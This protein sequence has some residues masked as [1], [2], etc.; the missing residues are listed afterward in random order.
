MRIL[1]VTAAGMSSR[2]A[3]SLG[4]E[5]LKCIYYKNNFEESMLYRM[6]H[7]DQSFDK[8]LIVGGYRWEELKEAVDTYFPELRSGITLIKNQKYNIYGSGFS[9]YLG[10]KEAIKIGFDELVFAEGDLLVDMESFRKV[11]CAQRDVVTYVRQNICADQSVAFYYD[12][13]EHIHYV[14][15]TSHHAFV[16]EEPFTGIFHSG[17]IWKFRDQERMEHVL[18]SM[19]EQELQGTN[20]VMIRNYFCDMPKEQYQMIELQRWVN[21]NTMDDFYQAM[22]AKEERQ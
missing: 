3:A 15:D 22:S 14:Y 13:Q 6:L 19:E 16:I 18:G 7:Y 9:L 11:V 1:L 21:C 5:C 17:Q 10:L 12:L 8:Y 4:M 2:F 20:L